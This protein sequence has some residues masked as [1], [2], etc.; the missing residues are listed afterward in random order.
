MLI[1]QLW[2]GNE[3]TSGGCDHT[4][5]HTPCTGGTISRQAACPS[6]AEVF[7]RP[8]AP[9]QQENKTTRIRRLPVLADMA[10]SCAW[11]T[12]EGAI[13]AS[14]TTTGWGQNRLMNKQHYTNRHNWFNHLQR[15]GGPLPFSR[16]NQ[17][18]ATTS[19]ANDDLLYP[20]L[21]Y[22]I[23][24]SCMLPRQHTVVLPRWQI[25]LLPLNSTEKHWAETI[26]PNLPNCV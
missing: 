17:I 5:I 11:S 21:H 14:G 10:T 25:C 16:W 13:E 26:E 12:T 7:I 22:C 6:T 4:C 24:Q 18:L 23:Y 20:K 15:G 3:A 8:G 1:S 19:F 2:P 9:S